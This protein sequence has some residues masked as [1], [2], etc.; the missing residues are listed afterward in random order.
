MKVR[1]GIGLSSIATA[2]WNSDRFFEVVDACEQLGWDSIW[3]SERAASD[4]PDTLVAMAA[5]AGRTTRLKF[6]PS[7]LVA[8]GRN[9]ILL[10]KQLATLDVISNGR[11]VAAFG[12]GADA[13]GEAQVFGTERSEAAGRTEEAVQLIKMLWTQEKVTFEGRYF[14]VNELS[15]GPK[16]LQN[17]H[18]DVW[19]GGTSTPALRRVATLGEGWLPSFITAGEYAEK[20]DAIRKLAADVE[21][22]IDEEHFGALIPYLPPGAGADGEEQLLAFVAARRPGVEPR[23]MVVLGDDA[24]LR[25]R[26]EEFIA[27]GASKFV[28]TP[29]IPPSD[30]SAELARVRAEVAKPLEN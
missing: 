28:L 20:A 3:F 2:G 17:P 27:Q 5:V 10:A 7:V 18:P 9:P 21:R 29:I 14:Q 8:P 11:F 13:R 19:F 4:A 12:L 15:I 16:P 25:T 6:G 1:V 26:L 23:D 22:V 24:A 30:W